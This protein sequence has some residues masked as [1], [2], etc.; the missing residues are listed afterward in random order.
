MYNVSHNTLDSETTLEYDL[1]Y[2][3]KPLQRAVSRSIN[4]CVMT[5]KHPS[6]VVKPKPDS[7]QLGTMRKNLNSW[8]LFLNY[9]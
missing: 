8:Q 7:M 3:T 5:T 9:H 2:A 4:M 6:I 1:W